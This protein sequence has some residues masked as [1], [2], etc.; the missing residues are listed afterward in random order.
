MASF[1]VTYQ[2]FN[3]DAFNTYTKRFFNL[4]SRSRIKSVIIRFKYGRKAGFGLNSG[5]WGRLLPFGN[6]ATLENGDKTP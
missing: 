4:S 3:P 5:V 6:K 1:F 2:T